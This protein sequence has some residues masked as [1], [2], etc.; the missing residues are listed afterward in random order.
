MK[1]TQSLCVHFF[2][3]FSLRFQLRK[4]RLHLTEGVFSP[5]FIIESSY[6]ATC[7]A[8]IWTVAS[9]FAPSKDTTWICELLQ[10]FH[11]L[12]LYKLSVT[13]TQ[14]SNG[15][16]ADLC[17]TW[18]RPLRMCCYE[19]MNTIRIY[20][21]LSQYDPALLLVQLSHSATSPNRLPVVH[22]TKC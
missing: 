10:S 3:F 8:P 15:N 20:E 11:I 5:L 6:R 21:L 22:H 4:H 17:L 19:N 1:T 13:S 14:V 7:I 16:F 2:Q 12:P 9:L 18:G